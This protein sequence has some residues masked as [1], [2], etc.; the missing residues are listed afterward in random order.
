MGLLDFVQQQHAVRV[1]I[2]GVS[3]QPA[4]VEADI[5]GRRADR[6]D[7]VCRSMYSDMSKRVISIPRVRAS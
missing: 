7:T 1:L 6:R 2:D 4:L 5:T 3:Q